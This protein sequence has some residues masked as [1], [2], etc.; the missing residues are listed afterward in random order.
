M[1]KVAIGYVLLEYYTSL[2]DDVDTYETWN[3]Q[4]SPSLA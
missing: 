3:E 2:F 4:T 1:Q